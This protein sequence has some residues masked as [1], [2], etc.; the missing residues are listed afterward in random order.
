MRLLMSIERRL[1]TASYILTTGIC[2]LIALYNRMSFFGGSPQ[3]SGPTPLMIAKTEM[4][5]Y[6]D[7]F[8]RQ[9]KK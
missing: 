9:E 5:M 7:M 3:P 8:N 4:E 1:N 2:Y 6:T